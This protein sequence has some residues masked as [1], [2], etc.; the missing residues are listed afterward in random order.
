MKKELDLFNLVHDPICPVRKDVI[1][2]VVFSETWKRLMAQSSDGMYFESHT[3]IE[4]ILHAMPIMPNQRLATVLASVVTWLGTN[5]GLGFLHSVPKGDGSYKSFSRY[6]LAWTIENF[7]E[8]GINNG[9]RTLE[10]CMMPE[11]SNQFQGYRKFALP[12]LT[13]DDYEAVEHLM[14]WFG[15]TSEGQEFL[16]Y[17]ITE[18]YRQSEEQRKVQYLKWKEDN[19]KIIMEVE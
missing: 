15:Q 14:Y 16:N 18:T 19:S 3:K 6:L 13:D 12:C 4:E 10:H 8:H 7:R 9:V 11:R 5:C 17:C 1:G 2:E